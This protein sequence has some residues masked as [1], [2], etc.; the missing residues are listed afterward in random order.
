MA[1]AALAAVAWLTAVPACAYLF[2]QIETGFYTRFRRYFSMLSDGASLSDLD[3]AAE[4]LRKE[5]R[6]VLTGTAAIQGTVG[7]LGI[8]LAPLLV[9]AL[10]LQIVGARAL[11]FLVIGSALQAISLATTILLHYFDFRVEAFMVALSLFVPN[12][13]LTF[14]SAVDT[15][16][17]G[18]GFLVAC[19]IS[20]VV[21]VT[22]LRNRLGTLVVGTFQDQPLGA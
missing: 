2:I 10:G 14:V 18:L 7:V 12:A 16:F 20:C 8:A 19:A 9:D 22:F 5:A 3:L 15:V 11:Q 21:A 13:I 17:L 4:G 6:H 1:Y